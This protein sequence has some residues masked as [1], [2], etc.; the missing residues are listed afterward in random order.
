LECVIYDETEA[1]ITETVTFLWSL[2]QY[3]ESKTRLVTSQYS[4]DDQDFVFDFATLQP[5]Q[6]G[7]LLDANPT[8]QFFFQTGVWNTERSL[9]LATRQ[10]TMD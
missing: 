3:P 10:H 2:K 8:R 9:V 5:E 7:R 6:L 1:S 4:I